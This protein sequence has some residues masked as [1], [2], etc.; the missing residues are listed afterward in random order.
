MFIT[1]KLAKKLISDIQPNIPYDLNMM[2][3][4]GLILA[5]TQ[6]NRVSTEHEGAS[7][8]IQSGL[9]ELIIYQ[10]NQ[11]EGCRKGVNL[12]I[13]F[14]YDIIGV[15][16]IT[17]DPDEVL[18]YGR[19]I[20][21]MIEMIVMDNYEATRRSD[22]EK[23]ESLLISDLI[24]GN[25][26]NIFSPIEIRLKHFFM[27]TEGPFSVGIIKTIYSPM[28]SETA[29]V[30]ENVVNQSIIR[31]LHIHRIIVSND[32]NMIIVVANL[33]SIRLEALL[34]D[35]SASL[36]IHYNAC[37]LATISN[38]YADYSDIIKA[39]NEASSLL[40]YYNTDLFQPGIYMF[41]TALLNFTL[42]QI[43][44]MYKAHVR[45]QCFKNL[46]PKE[47]S[48]L[49]E[50]IIAYFE[51]NGSLLK[52]SQKYY[53]HK[54]TVQY[55]IQKILKQTGFDIRKHHDLFILYIAAVS[56]TNKSLNHVSSKTGII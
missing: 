5:S 8:I 38:E 32:G 12:P 4:N 50:F 53:I 34:S 16:G 46:S 3:H 22:D 30:W 35:L 48:D 49:C 9:E 20:Q 26:A 2:D 51:S 42:N 17:G 24:N 23:M 39:F 21:K 31:K 45:H 43:P 19:I 14:L 29:E 25:I 55:K 37:F 40:N 47:I 13:H 7:I 27:S 44:N 54:N 15:V 56:Y 11:Y 41:D 18:S 33:P 6:E 52:F 36:S 28:K 1:T 10:D